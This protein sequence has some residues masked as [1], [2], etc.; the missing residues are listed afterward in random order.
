MAF[1][2]PSKKGRFLLRA[3]LTG[4]CPRSEQLIEITRAA[5]R[6][7]ASQAELDDAFKRDVISLVE[8]QLDAGL[9]LVVDGQLNWQDLF[10]PFSKLLTGIELGGLSRWFDNNT[11]YRKPVVTE[12]VRL[13]SSSLGAYFRGDL[14]PS[15][16][17]KKAILPGPY[18]FAAM[19]QNTAYASFADLVDDLAHALS[20]CLRELVKAGYEYF[21]FNEPCLSLKN[22]SLIHI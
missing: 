12:K 4:V 22:L 5:E 8:L 11:F 14:L 18:T 16:V 21:Q 3:H 1:S 2:N 7:C 6:G 13:A 17:R 9:D 20:N 15:T 10:R 19:S